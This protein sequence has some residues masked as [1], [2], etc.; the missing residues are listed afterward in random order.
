MSA[1]AAL[2]Y[3]PNLAARALIT[4]R[5]GIVG[6]AVSYL[7]NQFYPQVL[8]TLSQ[9][10]AQAGY[11]ML[12]FT[13]KRHEPSDPILEEVM[14]YRV[15]A[16]LLL[17]AS[18][19]SRFDAECQK[20]GIPVI[21]VNRRTN[22]P[23]V[24][25]VT[26]DNH[27]GAST[28]AAFLAAGGH[29]RFAFM[30]G[31][32]DASTSR[33]REAG[34]TRHLAA[35]GFSPPLRTVGHYD[36]EAASEAA[37]DLLRTGHRPDALFCANDHMAL[38]AINVARVEFQLDVGRE[39]SIVGFDDAGPAAWPLFSLTT[40]VQPVDAM[41]EGVITILRHRLAD[42]GIP[43]ES[44]VAPGWLAVRG[45]ARRPT[46]GVVARDSIETWSPPPGS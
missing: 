21:L 28:I 27:G 36:F 18:L 39:L 26:G 7:E 40:Y 12:L 3:R 5:S 41:V 2:G 31:L 45:S 11:R 44:R 23:N 33:E 15:D 6:V 8:E 32:E 22:S 37:R 38:A 24:W 42:P 29:R 4:R 43:A 25:S 14:R 35:Q 34:F 16:I 9:A 17:S 30:A 19:S 13:A 1:A 46:Q 10:L 20:A